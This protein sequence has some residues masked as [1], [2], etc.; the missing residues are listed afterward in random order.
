MA[1]VAVPLIVGAATAVVSQVL[2]P[3][4]QY[5]Q[6]AAAAPAPAPEPVTAAPS[7]DSAQV[8]AAQRKTIAALSAQQGRASTI[9][10]SGNSKDGDK[11]GG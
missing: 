2:S 11:L 9:L 8:A 4:P 10:T 5:V 1:A 3:K 7:P 6:Q